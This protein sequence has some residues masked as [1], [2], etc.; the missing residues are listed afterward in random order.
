MRL[1]KDEVYEALDEKIAIDSQI[2]GVEHALD[3]INGDSDLQELI[4]QHAIHNGITRLAFGEYGWD[5]SPD[6]V[7]ANYMSG[8]GIKYAHL[9]IWEKKLP[10]EHNQL[11]LCPDPNEEIAPIFLRY[12]NQ[13]KRHYS[14]HT[15]LQVVSGQEGYVLKSPNNYKD[16]K[17]LV[18]SGLIELGPTKLFL[19]RFQKSLE[20][21]L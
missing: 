8:V 6:P 3:A 10:Y 19:E 12:I 14:I 11:L 15:N 20:E 2:I 16:G 1:F 5:L 7:K 9:V 4:K 17:R 18:H 21:I 13:W